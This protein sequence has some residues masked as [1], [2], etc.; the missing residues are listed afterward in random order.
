MITK[1][2][3]TNIL[4]AFVEQTYGSYDK[5][6]EVEARSQD[7]L[8]KVGAL[9]DGFEKEARDI[10]NRP[11]DFVHY[12]DIP[13]KLKEGELNQKTVSHEQLS[14]YDHSLETNRLPSLRAKYDYVEPEHT[15]TTDTSEIEMT[16]DS[17]DNIDPADVPD[18]GGIFDDSFGI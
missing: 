3:T 5:I 1:I 7:V 2:T 13:T 17:Y 12:M 11:Q 10:L 16:T 4:D 6:E 8:D 18:L 15:G 9:K 14:K